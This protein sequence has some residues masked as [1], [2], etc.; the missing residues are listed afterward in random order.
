MKKFL[1]LLLALTMVSGLGVSAKN[2]VRNTEHK[3]LEIQ[4]KNLKIGK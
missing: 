3:A 4:A 1:S 2:Y